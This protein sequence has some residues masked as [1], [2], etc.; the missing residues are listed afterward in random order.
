MP[1][2]MAFSTSGC[3]SRWGTRASSVSGAIFITTVSRSFQRA[4]SILEVGLEK[5]EFLAQRHLLRLLMFE[6]A[7]QEVAEAGKHSPG[8]LSLRRG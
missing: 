5:G 7:A 4:C 8:G 3:R 2:R 1:W 6:G